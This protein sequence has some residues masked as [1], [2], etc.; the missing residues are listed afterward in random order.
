M[1][2]IFNAAAIAAHRDACE[3]EILGFRRLRVRSADTG[4]RLGFFEEIVP[5]GEGVPLHIHHKE[6]EMFN[7]REGH[8]RIWCADE[9]FDVHPG[10]VVVLPRG[11]PHAFRNVGEVEGWLDVT[12][13]PGGFETM[14]ARAAEAGTQ[15]AERFLELAPDYGLEMLPGQAAA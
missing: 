1:T 2:A 5:P 9:V 6:D 4:G 12:V 13:T 8:F 14:F 11:V 3:N 15:G 10:D 7:V